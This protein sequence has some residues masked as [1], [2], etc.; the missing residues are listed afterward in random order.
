MLKHLKYKKIFYKTTFILRVKENG[1]I[2]VHAYRTCELHAF[3]NV[4]FNVSQVKL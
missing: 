2:Y 1:L 3:L 4:L